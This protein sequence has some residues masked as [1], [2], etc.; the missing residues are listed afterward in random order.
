MNRIHII[1]TGP[2]TGTTLMA[3]AINACCNIDYATEHEDRLYARPSE[4]CSLYMTKNPSDLLI[5]WPSLLVDPSL[6]IICMIRDPRDAIVS[7]HSKNKSLYWSTLRYWKM[8]YPLLKK[9]RHHPRFIEVKYEDFVADPDGTQKQLLEQISCMKQNHKFSDYHEVA[10]PSVEAQKALLKIR[11]IGPQGIGAWKDNL[12]RIKQQ[13]DIHGDITED[14]VELGY[15]NSSEW[16]SI[17]DDIEPYQG[18]SHLPEFFSASELKHRTKYRYIE[19][20]RR[21]LAR[22]GIVSPYWPK[23]T[24]K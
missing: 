15:E 3:E 16:L 24:Q 9:Y 17:M 6:Y 4:P 21:I 5:V 10:Q 7:K 12:S 8:F 18:D 13:I 1:G 2:R 11:P 22:V 23:R 19:A 20:L 14:L